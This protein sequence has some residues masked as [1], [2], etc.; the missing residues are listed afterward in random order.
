MSRPKEEV[1]M[2]GHQAIG[3]DANL[4]MRVSFRENVLKCVVVRRFL[5]QLESADASVQYMIG[6]VP[7]SEARA[8][9]HGASCIETSICQSRNT[10]YAVKKDS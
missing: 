9:W 1:P 3:G 8:A 7:S 10:H 6:K 2:I 4:G 5:E